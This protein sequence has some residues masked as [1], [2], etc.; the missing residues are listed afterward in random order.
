MNQ[1]EI[2]RI[3]HRP[4]IK[5][6]I[7]VLNQHYKALV[8]DKTCGNTIWKNATNV[9]IDQT[10]QYKAFQFLCKG[11]RRPNEHAMTHVYLVHDAIQDK[12]HQYRL[13]VGGHMMELSL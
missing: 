1:V 7:R 9:E 8:F 12:R 3:R 13:L 10:Y 11:G 4:M 5:F 2:I 6:K